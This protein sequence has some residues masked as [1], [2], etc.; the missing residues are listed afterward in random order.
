MPKKTSRKPAPIHFLGAH[1][2][3][4]TTGYRVTIP[5]GRGGGRHRHWCRTLADAEAWVEANIS[6][7]RS[8][9]SSDIPTPGEIELL[10]KLQRIA[11]GRDLLDLVR[12][13]VAHRAPNAVTASSRDA[14]A[15]FLA[16]KREA[17]RRPKTL[18]G[19]TYALSHLP[20]ADDIRKITTPD[21]ASALKRFDGRDF[22]N[23][24]NTF[25]SFFRWGIAN[26]LC[27]SV[28]SALVPAKRIDRRIP[29]IYSSREVARVLEAAKPALVPLLALALFAGIRT[30]AL[31]RLDDTAVNLETGT[32]FVPGPADKLHR[33]YLVEM[34]PNLRAWLEAY[35]FRPRHCSVITIEKAI[36]EAFVAAKVPRRPNAM[37]HSFASH[38]LAMSG[39]AVQTA[40]FLGHPHGTDTLFAHY[41]HL[42]TPDR[43]RAFFAIFP[44][45]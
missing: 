27:E 21:I 2:A 15:R 19:Y 28:P 6:A 42:V 5:R 44:P 31:V 33:G 12:W 35:P 23:H 18:E 22:N 37:R 34:T 32:V 38:Y 36:R 9:D 16:E 8:S 17:G 11:A 25:N 45:T 3:P 20:Q 24:R 7:V 14:V 4:H 1:I 43:G 39:D 13:A 30:S 26:G 40:S 29:A 10:R 41:R